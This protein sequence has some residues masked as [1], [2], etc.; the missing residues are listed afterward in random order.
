NYIKKMTDLGYSMDEIQKVIKK[1]GFPKTLSV[2]ESKVTAAKHLTVGD[3]A[4]KVGVS[5]RTL[6]HWEEKGIIEADMRSSGGFRL[7]SETYVYLC[8]LIKDLQLFGYSLEE[9]KRISGEFRDFLIMEKNIDIYPPKVTGK[10]LDVM[11]VEIKALKER[12]KLLKNGIGRW[13]EL[14][15]K[16]V[17][18]INVLNKKNEKRLAEKIKPAEKKGKGKK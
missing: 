1:V 8:N 2:S 15:N 5:T 6:K 16:K 7:Y 13:D 4:A 14:V 10:K 17:K 12:M 11:S 3:L 9:I 18:E